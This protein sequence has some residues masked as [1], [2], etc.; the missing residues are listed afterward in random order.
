MNHEKDALTV[1]ENLSLSFN[2]KLT[3]AFL[4]RTVLAVVVAVAQQRLGHALPVR[5]ATG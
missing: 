3:A 2:K 1:R 4:V 5:T